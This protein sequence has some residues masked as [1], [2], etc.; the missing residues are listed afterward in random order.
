MVIKQNF[1][2]RQGGSCN[3]ILRHISLVPISQA[4]SRKFISPSWTN[5][6]KLGYCMRI[7]SIR[8]VK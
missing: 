6:C 8:K 5:D 1:Q 4:I 7:Q 2:H 3:T